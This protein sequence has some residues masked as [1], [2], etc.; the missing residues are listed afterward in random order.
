MISNT[1]NLIDL[2]NNFSKVFDE[3]CNERSGS[4]MKKYKLDG[5]KDRKSY[6]CLVTYYQPRGRFLT[7]RHRILLSI[8]SVQHVPSFSYLLVK[9]L[10][11]TIG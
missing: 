5:G 11:S 3:L 1:G 6:N 7:A 4:K 9:C 8:W 2:D 10:S